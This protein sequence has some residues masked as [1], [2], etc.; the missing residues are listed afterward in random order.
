MN[1]NYVAIG[2]STINLFLAGF[3]YYNAR[4]NARVA[5]VNSRL[6]SNKK[7]FAGLAGDVAGSL[8]T[9]AIRGGLVPLPTPTPPSSGGKLVSK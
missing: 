5:Q 1:W 9:K 8:I 4:R 2:V 7:D 3:N 6:F